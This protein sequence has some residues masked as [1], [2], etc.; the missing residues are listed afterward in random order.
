MCAPKNWERFLLAGEIEY[1]M[2]AMSGVVL[3]PSHGGLIDRF[4]GKFLRHE[5]VKTVMDI[6]KKTTQIATLTRF[7]CLAFKSLNLRDVEPPSTFA[8]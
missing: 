6:A 8:L 2:Y 1:K 4:H 7:G 5:Q 3:H